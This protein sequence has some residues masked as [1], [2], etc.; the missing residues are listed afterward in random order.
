[1]K[2]K[3]SLWPRG[4]Y[5]LVV[6]GILTPLGLPLLNA[7]KAAAGNLVTCSSVSLNSA[8]MHS[9]AKEP[10][11]EIV[12]GVAPR[13]PFMG[14]AG[15]LDKDALDS[16]LGDDVCHHFGGLEEH[17]FFCAGVEVEKTDFLVERPLRAP[18]APNTLRR[19]NNTQSTNGRRNLA[20]RSI[21]RE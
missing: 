8:R 15:R 16:G 5:D 21:L 2:Q 6:G 17:R 9:L 13:L 19:D 7:F 14:R 10:G 11:R 18:T 4:V 1:L 12:K 3:K 20:L